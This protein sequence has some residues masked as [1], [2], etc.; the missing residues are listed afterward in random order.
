MIN[1]TIKKEYFKVC[2]FLS[3]MDSSF[4]ASSTVTCQ[5]LFNSTWE[6]QLRGRGRNKIARD[7]SEQELQ[8]V[9][10]I[11]IKRLEREAYGIANANLFLPEEVQ[12]IR[13]KGWL[14]SEEIMKIEEGPLSELEIRELQEK[15]S[16]QKAGFSRTESDRLSQGIIIIKKTDPIKLTVPKRTQEAQKLEEQ[17]Y[18]STFTRGLDEVIE[19]I[20]IAKQLWQLEV[21]PLTS[22]IDYFAN[23]MLEHIEY[24][25]KG[26]KNSR[27]KT[28]IRHL[29]RYARRA[30][31][32]GGST[33]AEW[34]RFN[35]LLVSILTGPR[36]Q[37]KG[38][39]L[40]HKI[41]N[42]YIYNLTKFPQEI[43]MPSVV[44]GFGIIALNRSFS[45][46]I[47]PVGMLRKNESFVQ[48]GVG[49]LYF[50]IHDL[51]HASTNPFYRFPQSYLEV[52][53]KMQNLPIEKRKN[54]E[55][56]YFILS[57]EESYLLPEKEEDIIKTLVSQF[58]G[59]P[60]LLKDFVNLLRE[61]QSSAM[62]DQKI[63]I[64]IQ[65]FI[66]VFKGQKPDISSF[67]REHILEAR[68]KRKRIKESKGE[69]D[70]EV[71]IIN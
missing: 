60:N 6:K 42:D 39:M 67:F 65:D 49:P 44:G 12:E 50:F 51:D 3:L 20:A 58:L 25:E 43:F 69:E 2:I 19:W 45:E 54:V 31:Q 11:H 27:Q 5:N 13:E 8:A 68:N 37:A 66:E 38:A 40:I 59:D 10:G 21:D 7:L 26:V 48:E 55:L 9:K 30:V 33:Y 35:Y 64:V 63:K 4:S 32:N 22:R 47:Y 15:V 14:R 71:T 70:I 46:G 41:I 23:K 57:H 52:M 29:K 61:D 1:F 18:G 28:Q 17:G 24:M 56:A 34:I 36:H 62:I 53:K 16:L